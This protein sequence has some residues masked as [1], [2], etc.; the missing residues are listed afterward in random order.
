MV[1]DLPEPCATNS[2]QQV[3]GMKSRSFVLLVNPRIRQEQICTDNLA[4]ND[5]PDFNDGNAIIVMK[6]RHKNTVANW[7]VIPN[8][9]A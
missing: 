2:H 1:S 4:S 8:T 7:A 9:T 5:I 6:T 3:P